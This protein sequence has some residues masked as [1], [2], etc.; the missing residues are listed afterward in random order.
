MF[1]ADFSIAMSHTRTFFVMHMQ[2][3]YFSNETAIGVYV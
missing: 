2:Q 3:T 1:D